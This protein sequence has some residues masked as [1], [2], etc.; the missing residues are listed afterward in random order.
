MSIFGKIKD[1]RNKRNDEAYKKY[2]ETLKKILTTKE[3]RLEAI[4]ILCKAEPVKSIPLLMNRYEMVIDHGIQD[5][6]EKEMISEYIVKN[7]ELAKP[8][9]KNACQN[10]K[11]ISWPLRLAE[12]IFNEKE[13][14]DI[15]L[16]NLRSDFIEFD[17]ALSERNTE[18][19]LAL[20]DVKDERIVSN[21]ANLVKSRDESVRMAAVECLDAHGADNEVVK[22]IILELKLEPKTDDSSRFHGLL[23][24]ICQ[25]H[26]W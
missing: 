7:K 13:Y 19:L 12:R 10:N 5:S 14:V 8:V 2:G 1:Y 3:Q 24:S 21:A 18:I 20:R 25:R 9:V 15:L 22:K 6:R 26:N 4:E 23:E 16:E 17:E 11:R